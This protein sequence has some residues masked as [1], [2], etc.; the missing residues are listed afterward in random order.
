MKLSSLYR[1]FG[2]ILVVTPFLGVYGWMKTTTEIT[3][4][5]LILIT[6]GSVGKKN[7]KLLDARTAHS[8]PENTRVTL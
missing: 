5:I 1:L 8:T 7:R 3:I 6:S 4:G 2:I